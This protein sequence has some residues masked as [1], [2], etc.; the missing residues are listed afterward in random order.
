MAKIRRDIPMTKVCIISLLAATL[1]GK[2][3]FILN[4]VI[5]KLLFIEVKSFEPGDPASECWSWD[6]NP[7]LSNSEPHVFKDPRSDIR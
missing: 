2:C 3:Y 4:L 1:L 6:L 7:S 5:T